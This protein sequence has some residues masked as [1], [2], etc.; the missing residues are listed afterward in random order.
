MRGD[1]PHDQHGKPGQVVATPH[2][3]GST[4][5]RGGGVMILVGYPACAGIDLPARCR[6][7]RIPRLPRMRGDRPSSSSGSP[8]PEKATPHARGSTRI[9]PPVRAFGPGYPACAGIDPGEWAQASMNRG[10][11]RMRGDRPPHRDTAKRRMAATPH[12]RGSTWGKTPAGTEGAGYPAC[13]GIDPWSPFELP[14]SKR[15]PRMRGDR[16]MSCRVL[17]VSCRATPHARGSTW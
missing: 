9:P 1:R 2:A 10:L 7:G 3:R 12:A 14:H 6:L 11:P 15:L 16:P 4:V 17:S 13:A 5:S 8:A